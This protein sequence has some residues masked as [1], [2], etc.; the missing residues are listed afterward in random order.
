MLITPA[1]GKQVD[2]TKLLIS[3]LRFAATCA[4]Y[5]MAFFIYN[6]NNNNGRKFK[7]HGVSRYVQV[8]IVRCTLA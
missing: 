1:R 8:V 2:K 6:N 7:I 4:K 5:E 3:N